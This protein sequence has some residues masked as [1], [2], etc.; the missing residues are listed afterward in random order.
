MTGK[1]K[2]RKQQEGQG[3][4]GNVRVTV[5]TRDTDGGGASIS[6]HTELQKSNDRRN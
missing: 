4:T 5:V 2:R 3:T 6:Y 1:R